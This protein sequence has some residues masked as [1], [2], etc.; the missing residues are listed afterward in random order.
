M[1]TYEAVFILDERK[2]EGRGDDFAK[3]VSEF[4]KSIG[5]VVKESHCLGRRHFAYKIQKK[6]AGIYWDF[7]LDLAPEHVKTLQDK[8]RL[9]G[10]VLRLVVFLYEAPPKRREAGGGEVQPAHQSR[11]AA[12]RS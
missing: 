11:E 6:S 7:V 9:D 2:V 12:G 4:M 3:K 10:T 8:Y 1:R 5:G